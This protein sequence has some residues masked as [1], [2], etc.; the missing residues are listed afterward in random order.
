M[1]KHPKITLINP[2]W[3]FKK[4]FPPT[5][6]AQL[7]GYIREEGFDI[8]IV[9]LNYIL[10][11]EKILNIDYLINKSIELVE[12]ESPSLVGIICDTIHLPFC[13]EFIPKF[14]KI[15]KKENNSSCGG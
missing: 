10:S 4:V 3:S 7:A 14:R 6:L 9:D 5:N 1:K 2:F 15:I 13:L 8:S 12:R 11:K